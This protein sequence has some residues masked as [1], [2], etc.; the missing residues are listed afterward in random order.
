MCSTPVCCVAYTARAQ[1][2]CPPVERASDQA[3]LVLDAAQV[4]AELA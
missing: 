3:A 4:S 2:T 1:V